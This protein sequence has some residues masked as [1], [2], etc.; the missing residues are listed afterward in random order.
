[1]FLRWPGLRHPAIDDL[2]RERP[3]L[4]GELRDPDPLVLGQ[5]LAGAADEASV[6]DR[7]PIADVAAVRAD[8]VHVVA[9]EHVERVR[10]GGAL[11]ARVGLQRRDA[12]LGAPPI[13]ELDQ[14]LLQRCQEAG[15]G[16]R[17][18]ERRLGPSGIPERRAEVGAR[19]AKRPERADQRQSPSEPAAGRRA[20]WAHPMVLQGQPETRLATRA[21][22]PRFPGSLYQASSEGRV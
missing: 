19:G 15:P 6:Q 22:R 1:M 13:G 2:D 9:V 17:A 11:Q 8:V 4:V 10:P 16:W 18:G 21:R 14:A 3:R 7:D 5:V 20:A 12:G